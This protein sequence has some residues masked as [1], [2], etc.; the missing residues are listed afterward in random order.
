MK[1]S[2]VILEKEKNIADF[3]GGTRDGLMEG[4]QDNSKISNYWYKRGYDFGVTLYS[5]QIGE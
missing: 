5:E 4:R 2:K 1:I 3:E